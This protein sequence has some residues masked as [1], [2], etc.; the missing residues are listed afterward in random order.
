MKN[1]QSKQQG[2]VLVIGLLMLLVITMVGVTAMSGTTSNERMAANHQFQSLSF[3]AAE[4]AIQDN[5]NVPSVVPSVTTYPVSDVPAANN[6]N[7][8]IAGGNAVMVMANANIQFCGEELPMGSGFCNG[9][10]GACD[11]DQVFDVRGSGQVA[12][13][14]TQETHM[15]R[16]ARA[17]M[18][19]GMPF[20][21]AVCNEV[22]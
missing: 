6:Y 12:A 13:L 16:G 14:G 2:V 5:F 15:R 11:I 20:D 3:Q 17:M 8:N 21:T 18:S 7:V 9:M 1:L 10:A 4:S 19:A 22:Q